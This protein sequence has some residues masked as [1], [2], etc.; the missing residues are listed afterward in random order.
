MNIMNK[1]LKTTALLLT[2]V[3]FVSCH[4]DTTEG[5]TKIT[6]YPSITVLGD[7]VT[8]VNQGENYNDAGCKVDLNGEDVTDQATIVSNV[9]S[10]EIGIYSVTYTAVNEDGFSVSVVREVY[11]VNPTSFASVYWGESQFGT[12]HYYDAPILIKQRSN[13]TYLIDDLAGGFYFNGRYPGYEPSYDFHL[14]AILNL[15]ADNT[16]TLVQTGSWY[17]DGTEMSLTSGSFN[18]DSQTIT[19]ELDFGGDPMYVTLTGVK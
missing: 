18:P 11:V 14:E 3:L 4:E 2:V 7:A 16:V 19:L 10:N 6:Y 15:E 13:G 12:R 5:F 17:W 8:I 1:I 9:N